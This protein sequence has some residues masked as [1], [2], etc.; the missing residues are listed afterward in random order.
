MKFTSRTAASEPVFARNLLLAA[1]AVSLAAACAPAR[2]A[3]LTNV[4]MQGTMAMVMVSYHSRDGSLQVMA[5][6]DVPQL[7]PLLA[8][9]PGDQ[10]NPAD[11]WYDCLDSSRQ[12]LAFS[13]RYGFD[14]DTSSDPLPAN[15]A[16][17]IRK[18]SGSPGLGIYRYRSTVPKTWTPIFGTDGSSDLLEWD[19]TMFHPA[20]AAPVGTNVLTATLALFLADAASGVPVPGTDSG[21]VVLNWTTL[22]DG[23]PN[24]TISTKA[25]IQWPLEATNYVLEA[26]DLVPAASWTSVTNSPVLLDGQPAVVLDAAW[27]HKVFRMRQLSP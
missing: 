14:M 12:G 15:T 21:P 4:P 25:V 8:S 2:A 19:L 20:F 9:N 13:R 27:A 22:P 6:S 1:C 5:P 11:P 7:T 23:R 17:W 10:F 18:L 16:L 26:A 24:L 3:I